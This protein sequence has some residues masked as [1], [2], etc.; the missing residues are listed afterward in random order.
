MPIIADGTVLSS[1]LCLHPAIDEDRRMSNPMIGIILEVYPVDTD[2]NLSNSFKSDCRGWRHECKVLVLENN[3]EPYLLLDN[4][5]IPPSSHSGIDNFEEE[6]PRGIG[7]EL[8]TGGSVP[9]YFEKVDPNDL[10]AEWCIVNF[11]GGSLDKPFIQGW[12][13]HPR[14][15][16][17][18]AT[19]G[20]AKNGP[21]TL[22]QV[23]LEKNRFRKFRR[24][25]GT[26][27]VVNTQGDVYLNTTEAN[28]ETKFTDSSINRTQFDSGGSIQVD[29]KASQQLEFNWNTPVFGLAA[30]SNSQQR[31]QDAS[32]PQPNKINPTPSARETIRTI[33][34]FKEYSA[35]LKTSQVNIQC[36]TEEESGEFTVLAEDKVT[37]MQGDSVVSTLSMQNGLIRI[38]ASD[39][40]LISVGNDTVSIVTPSGGTVSIAPGGNVLV[41]GSSIV[42]GAPCTIGTPAGQPL[43]KGTV[44]NTSFSGYLDAESNLATIN[45]SV[46]NQLAGACTSPPLSAL[47]TYF[48][49][50]STAWGV[51]KAA[52]ETIKAAK[53]S[54]LTTMITAV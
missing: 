20:K 34:R 53:S 46:F 5:V 30:G 40:S 19:A 49:Q 50:L 15:V 47:A 43:V 21:S 36:Q 32:L 24:L 18:P 31:K 16:F 6:L 14:N 3:A 37:L 27:F 42:L 4:V 13:H 39:G 38:I 11:I 17:D 9:K 29:V 7:K 35:L 1:S 52:V 41:T 8:L 51:Y 25:N 2:D 33:V 10:D 54:F 45:V 28:S 44:F 22:Q 48:T 12:W 23:N 26:Q